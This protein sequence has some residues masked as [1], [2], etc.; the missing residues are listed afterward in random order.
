MIF[1]FGGRAFVIPT[2]ATDMLLR[3]VMRTEDTPPIVVIGQQSIFMLGHKQRSSLSRML[4]D[5][6]A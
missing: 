4:K 1:T 3:S 6:D 2:F 5:F